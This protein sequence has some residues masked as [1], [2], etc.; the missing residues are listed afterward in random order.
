MLT[1]LKRSECCGAPYFYV[2]DGDGHYSCTGCDTAHPAC[3][4]FDCEANRARQDAD[5]AAEDRE[6]E[7]R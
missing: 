3:D 7:D 5:D 2:E 6:R 4:C 1:M